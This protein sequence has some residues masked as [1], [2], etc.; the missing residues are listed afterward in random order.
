MPSYVPL[1][2]EDSLVV[3]IEEL[4]LE[5]GCHLEVVHVPGTYLI[6]Q[7]TDGLSR[8]VWL[9]PQRQFLGINSPTVHLLEASLFKR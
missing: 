3:K 8:G 5:L 6:M 4:E 9:S 2:C 7:G 1:G